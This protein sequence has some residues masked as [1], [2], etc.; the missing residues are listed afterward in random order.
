MKKVLA[1]DMGSSSIR[2][3]IGYI[4]E[5]RIENK[6]VMRMSHKIEEKDGRMRWEWD[7]IINCIADT[8]CE[9]A[10]EI[11]SVAVDTWGVD[12][13]ILDREGELISTP[14]AYRDERHS[15]GFMEALEA[16]GEESIFLNTGNQ[17]MSINSLYQLL[18][19]R[20][21]SKKEFDKTDKVLM[22]PAL[23]NYMICGVKSGEETIWSTSQLLNLKSGKISEKIVKTFGLKESLFPDI[24]KPGLLIGNTKNSKIKKLKDKAVDVVSVC[25]HDTAS[26]VILT[27]SF[28][29]QD[30]MFLS[31][32]TWSLFGVKVDEAVISKEV[33]EV[34]LTNELGLNSTT[35][36][37]KNLTGLYLL[38]K[39]KQQLEEKLERKISFSEISEYVTVSYNK[40]K[41]FTSLIDMEDVRF[42][43][44]DIKAREAIDEYLKEKGYKVLGNDFEYFR[45][46]YESMVYK[47]L[48]VKKL[49]EGITKKKYK[50]L[51]LIGGGARSEF[52]C[53]LLCDKLEMEVVAGPYEASALGNILV[54][55]LSL[56]E[57]KDIESAKEAA[58]KSEPI[59]ILN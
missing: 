7:R 49:I 6:E 32:G 9:Y 50:K 42:S 52:L 10:D 34:G 1:I 26:A 16:L 59:R 12:F 35:M 41:D 24:H 20:K 11:S 19:L 33:F 14:I 15:D 36:L 53:R 17:L 25:S 27:E 31:C 4:E 55:L 39:F 48:S 18:A 46:I 5:G 3:C 56:G 29:N 23:V 30:T 47:Y 57:V 38:E 40:D 2:G 37:F 44:E 28:T 8:I 54:Q 21:H 45:L 51:H 43:K 13:G 58:F 22:M